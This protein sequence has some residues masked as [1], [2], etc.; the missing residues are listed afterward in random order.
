MRGLKQFCSVLGGKARHMN[1]FQALPTQQWTKLV[2][3]E[4]RQ[5]GFDLGRKYL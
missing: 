3:S 1:I 4:G 5:N 2:K